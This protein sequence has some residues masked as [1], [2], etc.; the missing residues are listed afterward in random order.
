MGEGRGGEPATRHTPQ[1]RFLKARQS[2]P[3]NRDAKS[4]NSSTAV[5]VD[6][7]LKQEDCCEFQASLSYMVRLCQERKERK[8]KADTRTSRRTC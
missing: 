7:G 3:R 8:L 5:G 2:Q 4:S 1:Q 6:L